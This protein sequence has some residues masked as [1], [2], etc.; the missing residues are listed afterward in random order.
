MFKHD[1]GA[2]RYRRLHAAA[3]LRAVALLLLPGHQA[4]WEEAY[5][6]QLEALQIWIGRHIEDEGC[7]EV[8]GALWATHGH[9]PL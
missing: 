8:V 2:P 5:L 1:T 3:R 9:A 6:Q 7:A 4:A